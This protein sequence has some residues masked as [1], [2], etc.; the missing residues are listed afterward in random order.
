MKPSGLKVMG[1]HGLLSEE[2]MQEGDSCNRHAVKEEVTPV[3]K[4][5]SK[6][7]GMKMDHNQSNHD[8]KCQIVSICP[9]NVKVLTSTSTAPSNDPGE[10][11][12]GLRDAA[13]L[14]I[15][16]RGKTSK[17]GKSGKKNRIR[18]KT[19]MRV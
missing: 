11:R 6:G 4:E 13:F 3:S 8:P 19:R 9:V 12:K 2:E 7:N 1:F 17:Y 18:L 16:V 5:K 14:G 10:D 15:Q